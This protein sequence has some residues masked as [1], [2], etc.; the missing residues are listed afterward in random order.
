MRYIRKVCQPVL[1]S[2]SLGASHDH[3]YRQQ[4]CLNV[5]IQV[6]WPA[7]ASTQNVPCGAATPLAVPVG[8][9]FLGGGQGEK[10]DLL[11]EMTRYC[12]TSSIGRKR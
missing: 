9:G 7:R 1:S 5:H 12:S 4:A 6:L 2:G 10:E 11:S 8:W 3:W